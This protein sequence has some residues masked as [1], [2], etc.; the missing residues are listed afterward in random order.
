MNLSG[1]VLILAAH[2]DDEVLGCGATISKISNSGNEVQTLFLSDGETSRSNL[3]ESCDTLMQNRVI[4]RKDAAINAAKL[5]G[6]RVPIF[7]DYPDNQMDSVP[8]LE[9]AKKIEQTIDIFK[10]DIIFTHSG[11]DLNID[12]RIVHEACIIATRP[13]HTIVRELY[14]F[15]IP[16]SS[17]WNF[18]STVK[19][20]NPRLFID[21]TKTTNVK[22]EALGYYHD[23]I[24]TFPH[25]RSIEGIQSLMRLRGAQSGFE[26]AESFEIGRIL[27][28]SF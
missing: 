18:T 9:I 16:S 20:F 13:I 11:T 10:P 19:S 8:I 26:F 12:H 6:T 25:P 22:I 27:I 15:E 5:L 7:L 24:R 1:S 28:R 4:R 23:E 2:P 14:F 17:E 21:V 3:H